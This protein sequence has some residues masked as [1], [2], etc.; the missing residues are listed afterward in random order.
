MQEYASHIRK[1]TTT[2]TPHKNELHSPVCD[3]NTL[4][5]FFLKYNITPQFLFNTKQTQS[6]LQG[7]LGGGGGGGGGGAGGG[8]TTEIGVVFHIIM[9]NNNNPNIKKMSCNRLCV[10]EGN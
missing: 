4:V 2:T 5:Q 7:D 9:K 10:M 8:L 6:Q 3:G 1:T